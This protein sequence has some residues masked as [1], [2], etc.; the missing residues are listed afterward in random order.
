MDARLRFF[1]AAMALCAAWC[2]VRAVAFAVLGDFLSA[3]YAVVV[4]ALII[5]LALKVKRDRARLGP[6]HWRT[7]WRALERQ[8][9][10]RK[11]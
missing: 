3:G 2:L 1:M 5:G 6:D 9:R 7:S 11:P 4:A 8:L 10:R